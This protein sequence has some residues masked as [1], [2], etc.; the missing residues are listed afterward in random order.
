ME[1]IPKLPSS[2]QMIA[3]GGYLTDGMTVEESCLLCGYPFEA[4]RTHLERSASIIEFVK[5]KQVQLKH[6]LLK[7]VVSDPRKA[8]W[9]LETLHPN[10]FG[11]GRDLNPP[12]S[13]N[14]LAL[15]MGDIQNRRTLSGEIVE[16]ADE[17]VKIENDKQ[18]RN[19][20]EIEYSIASVL[21]GR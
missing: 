10:E 21:D 16:S 11:R 12:T 8:E 13:V 7:T 17:I 4:M 3:L 19:A 9:L 2:E 5:K 18:K 1:K 14:V 6:T 20:K 15:I